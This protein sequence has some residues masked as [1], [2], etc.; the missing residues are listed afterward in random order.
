MILKVLWNFSG[1]LAVGPAS[2][3]FGEAESE[4]LLAILTEFMGWSH[5]VLLAP[6]SP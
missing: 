4:D 1:G 3:V 5:A 6:S 2:A